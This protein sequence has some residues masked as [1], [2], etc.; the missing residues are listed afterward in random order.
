MKVRECFDDIYTP[1]FKNRQKYPHTYNNSGGT[2]SIGIFFQKKI[3]QPQNEKDEFIG[4]SFHIVHISKD[5]T[6]ESIK[7]KQAEVVSQFEDTKGLRD[8]VVGIER[9]ETGTWHLDCTIE[10]REKR[11]VKTVKKRFPWANKVQGCQGKVGMENTWNYSIKDGNYIRKPKAQGKRNDL[12]D[13]KKK[14]QDGVPIDDLENEYFAKFV[15][16]GRQLREYAQKV[17][18]KKRKRDDESMVPVEAMNW[19][20][21]NIEGKEVHPR[22][23]HWIYDPLGNWG[24][25][26]LTGYL[27]D[28]YDAAEVAGKTAD[29]AEMIRSYMTRHCGI[30]PKIVIIDIPRDKTDYINYGAIESLKNGSIMATKYMSQHLRFERP[31]VIVMAN[32]RCPS[33]ELVGKVIEHKVSDCQVNF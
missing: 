31:Q 10:Y 5:Y 32:V 17:N 9:A 28:N 3:M 4:L 20:K 15:Q 6:E 16:Y 14:I 11:T 29:I 27:T 33:N 23:I 26:A 30:G 18:E 8:W 22:H 2:L 13:I 19:F 7:E 21:E 25:S 24:K 1:I 12:E